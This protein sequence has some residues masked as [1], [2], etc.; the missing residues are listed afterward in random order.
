M[1]TGCGTMQPATEVTMQSVAKISVEANVYSLPVA[2]MASVIATQ[3]GHADLARTMWTTSCLTAAPTVCF[4]LPLLGNCTS[5]LQRTLSDRSDPVSGK[6]VSCR[7]PLECG[8]EST[9]TSSQDH[10]RNSERHVV[11]ADSHGRLVACVRVG[12]QFSAISVLQLEF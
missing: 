1:A 12:V 9:G 11:W 4:A 7:H 10:R 5:Q 8:A 3:A 2:Q 6:C